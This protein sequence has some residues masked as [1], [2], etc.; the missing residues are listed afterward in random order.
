MPWEPWPRKE[1]TSLARYVTGRATQWLAVEGSRFDLTEDS[2]GRRRLV[3]ALYMALS[4]KD[5]RYDLEGYHPSAALQ[6]IR[7]PAE[8]IEAPRVGTC[9]DLAALFCGLCLGNEL[10]P[11]LIVLDG[12]ALAAVSLTY[13]LRAWD[14]YRPEYEWFAK[15]PLTDPAKLRAQ[16]DRGEMLA[17]ECTGFARSVRLGQAEK[18]PYP[19]SVGRTA[20]GRLPFMRALEA[21]RAQLD[22]GRR[23]FGFA[24][25]IAVAHYAW[26]IEPH[27]LSGASARAG[28]SP[29]KRFL[30]PLPSNIVSRPKYLDTLIALSRSAN[31]TASP[32]QSRKPCLITS[33]TGMPGIGKTTIALMAANTLSSSFPDGQLYINLNGFTEGEVP[34]RPEIALDSLLQQLG[35]PPAEIPF[36]VIQKSSLWNTLLASFR[37]IIILDNARNVHQISAAIPSATPSLIIITSRNQMPELTNADKIRLDTLEEDQAC[38][39]F[40]SFFSFRPETDAETQALRDCARECGFLPLAIRIIASLW[41]SRARTF[42]EIA[43]WMQY[44]R[45]DNWIYRNS[46][47]DAEFAFNSSYRTLSTGAQTLFLA[48]SALPGRDF[49]IQRLQEVLRRATFPIDALFELVDYSLITETRHSRFSM[50][51]LLKLFGQKRRQQEVTEDSDSIPV[52]SLSYYQTHAQLL[53]QQFDSGILNKDTLRHWLLDELNNITANCEACL[54]RHS[55][56]VAQLIFTIAPY[57]SRFAFNSGAY[58]LLSMGLDISLSSADPIAISEAHRSIAETLMN[59]G[60]F[61]DADSHYTSSIAA[62]LKGGAVDLVPT[63]QTAKAFCYERLG[64]YKEGLALLAEAENAFRRRGDASGVNAVQNTRGAIF[65][66]LQQYQ[67]ALRCFGVD[68]DGLGRTFEV[69]GAVNHNNIGFTYYRLGDYRKARWHLFR[70]Y[71]TEK[72]A[73]NINS[74]LVSEVN[75]GYVYAQTRRPHAGVAWAERAINTASAADNHFQHG[76][77]LDALGDGFSAMGKRQEAA[78]AWKQAISI[79][80]LCHAPESAEIREKLNAMRSTGDMP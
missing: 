68:V 6:P 35:V 3:E 9:L 75:I 26:R 60:Q 78:T 29:E 32:P 57:C 34:L 18:D 77:A 67:D 10:L 76:R 40:A 55:S 51:D 27:D 43:T 4:E 65:W 69:D 28:G 66:R 54:E 50:H 59:I 33:L 39:L 15:G 44:S 24:L 13:A 31:I 47:S 58:L 2:D 63:L 21:G 46:D 7:T 8:V 62:A 19:E 74:M 14:N 70:S 71:R 45:R 5:I 80:D 41:S 56:S 38:S 23:P 72:A 25:D 11:V 20:E 42:S 52:A 61:A 12:H 48:C 22:E 30:P 1:I 17:V 64:K 53:M 79:F 49:T 37:G 36:N 16:I 73:G